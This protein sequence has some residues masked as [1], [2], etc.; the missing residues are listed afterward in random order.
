[1]KSD[2]ED[3]PDYIRYKKKESPWQMVAILGVGS[4]ITLGLIALLAKPMV[5]DLNQLK[6]GIRIGG[7]PIFSQQRAQTYSAPLHTI[8]E[9]PAPFEPAP[10]VARTP[11][12]QADIE[13]SKK[14]AQFA[15]ER[16]QNAFNDNNYTPK[17]ATNIVPAT[18][19]TREPVARQQKRHEIVVVGK[20]QIRLRDYCPYPRG[21]IEHRNCKMQADLDSRNR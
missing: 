6:Q 4:V 2:W 17:G 8:K 19:V 16:M 15:V 21:S 14:Q 5:I 11:L 9:V 13:W 1:M 3:A 18:P 20:E 12:S 10:Q 7:Q